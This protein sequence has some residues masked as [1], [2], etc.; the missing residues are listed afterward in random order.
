MFSPMQ[1]P[2]GTIDIIASH[3]VKRS[4]LRFKI[5]SHIGAQGRQLETTIF[6]FDRTVSFDRMLDEGSS[7]EKLNSLQKANHQWISYWAGSSTCS[8]LD[9]ACIAS[10]VQSALTNGST[11]FDSV[12]CPI[13]QGFRMK[14]MRGTTFKYLFEDAIFLPSTCAILNSSCLAWT[15]I[16]A[17]KI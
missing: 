5:H 7:H 9:F 12:A 6:V 2:D 13:M 8:K 14:F 15:L 11:R 4:K 3:T 16:T 10:D 17:S 1:V